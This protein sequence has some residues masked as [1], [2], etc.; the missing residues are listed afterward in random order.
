MSPADQAQPPQFAAPLPPAKLRGRDVLVREMVD[1][2]C[3]RAPP[4]PGRLAARIPIHGAAGMGKTAVALAILHHESIISTFQSHRIFFSCDEFSDIDD[5]CSALEF[6]L[7]GKPSRNPI[8]SVVAYLAHCPATLLILDGFDSA[9]L[10][11][12]K[13]PTVMA[14]K[15]DRLA[16]EL[17]LLQT[18]TLVVTMREIMHPRKFQW[19]ITTPLAALG[20]VS[21]EAGLQIFNDAA[22]N[23]LPTIQK[24]AGATVVQSAHCVPF[25]IASLGQHVRRTSTSPATLGAQTANGGALYLGESTIAVLRSLGI[26]L[27][28]IRDK[29]PMLI[30]LLFVCSHFP[31]GLHLDKAPELKQRFAQTPGALRELE[32]LGL[33]T[34]D[35]AGTIRVP[36]VV[37][38]V[39][40]MQ[41]PRQGELIAL[42]SRIY[43]DAL[44]DAKPPSRRLEL[45]STQE[46]VDFVNVG[47]MLSDERKP[48]ELLVKTILTSTA[49]RTYA[50]TSLHDALRLLGRLDSGIWRSSR[51]ERMA[52]CQEVIGHCH[53]QRENFADARERYEA[54]AGIWSALSNATGAAW[55]SLRVGQ[56][57]L[58]LRRYVDAGASLESARNAFHSKGDREGYAVTLYALGALCVAD[59]RQPEAKVHFKDASLQFRDL[60][61][62]NEAEEARGELEKLG[63]SSPVVSERSPSTTLSL[64]TAV[65]PTLQS[66]LLSHVLDRGIGTATLAPGVA[67]SQHRVAA[68]ADWSAASFIFSASPGTSTS[69]LGHLTPHDPLERETPR[70]FSPVPAES[71]FLR[72]AAPSSFLRSPTIRSGTVVEF[73]TRNPSHLHA[74]QLYARLEG[75]GSFTT[76]N[77]HLM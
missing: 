18:L 66:E 63:L 20:G 15:M 25:A 58:A 62:E 31:R 17:G 34:R 41:F 61:M 57:C 8:S 27:M 26:L 35:A 33:V 16:S 22:F 65:A 14:Q 9:R 11:P 4:A 53:A 37:R 69:E 48:D 5:L 68:S 24:R 42:A 72:R 50:W 21:P 12:A 45:V 6:Q 10:C 74:K 30:Q 29:S 56:C 7:V 3:K 47:V 71:V 32:E 23:G 36:R 19:T 28:G 38:D 76:F 59:G 73:D 67:K 44:H 2:I 64:Q 70:G 52:R 51:N 13:P 77:S 46:P 75:V 54:A 39:T 40:I 55:C 1:H 60:G 49:H 43:V